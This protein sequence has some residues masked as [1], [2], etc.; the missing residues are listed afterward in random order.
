LRCGYCDTAYAFHGGTPQSVDE[1][2]TQVEQLGHAHVC[3]TGGEPLA[4]PSVHELMARLCDLGHK[5]SL[6][7]SGA[8]DISD[9]DTRV[10]RIVDFKTPG[11]GEVGRNRWE[12]L[13]ALK[14]DD[15]VKFV[16]CSRED[17]D[18]ARMQVDQHRLSHR[19]CEVLFSPS[20]DE[21]DIA[22]LARWI[23]ADGLQVRLQ[24]QMH[25]LIWGNEPGR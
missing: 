10:V 3:V 25:K 2:V 12:N 8:L 9:V 11:S 20:H 22:Q 14:T 15:Q 1:L 7:T 5:V 17:D 21:L 23:L 16:L 6:E 4:Q 19:V 13:H 18:W 24:M